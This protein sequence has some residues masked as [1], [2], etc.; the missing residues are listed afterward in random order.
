MIH[1]ERHQLNTLLSFALDAVYGHAIPVT[2]GIL[3]MILLISN[4]G[5]R[6]ANSA[7]EYYRQKHDEFRL[8]CYITAVELQ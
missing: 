8:P 5:V 2:L 4:L 6:T 7:P 3:S 1:S